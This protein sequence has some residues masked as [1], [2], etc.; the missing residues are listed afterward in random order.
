MSRADLL[1]GV[2]RW[3]FLPDG[4]ADPAEKRV[5]ITNA[6]RGITALAVSDGSP[7]WNSLGASRPLMGLNG[8]VLAADTQTPPAVCYLDAKTGERIDTAADPL[9]LPPNRLWWPVAAWRE[10]DSIF[11]RWKTVE[12]LEGVAAIDIASGRVSAATIETSQPPPPARG[13]ELQLFLSSGGVP[14]L[15]RAGDRVAA[16]AVDVS[17][18]K[19]RLRL[20]TWNTS[21]GRAVKEK[22][23]VR[24]LPRLG[25]LEHHPSPDVEHIY[26][27][28]CNDHDEGG[29]LAG[30]ICQWLVFNVSDGKQV[31][32][33]PPP[34]DLRPPMA[35]IGTRLFYLESGFIP[36]KK[37]EPLRNLCAIDTA[38]GRLAWSHYVGE[39]GLIA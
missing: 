18:G 15:W 12:G 35:V 1:K 20:V 16:L 34:R 21:D 11:V 39:A 19:E 4:V 10:V 3:H 30:S 5:F 28:S 6:D 33:F 27:L 13:D 24:P 17:R 2:D 7:S 14:A 38:S 29:A 26:L 22:E 32:A 23:L 8:A 31:V 25:Y 36:H 9:P 37:A